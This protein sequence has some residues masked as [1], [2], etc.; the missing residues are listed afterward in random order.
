MQFRSATWISS[1]GVLIFIAHAFTTS[2]QER[3]V[4]GPIMPVEPVGA[5][6]DAFK[7]HDVVA[8]VDAHG[9]LQNHAFRL[10]LIRDL[11]FTA[12]V[13][14]IVVELGNARYQDVVDR[15]V[16][17]EDVA[18]A[19]LRNAWQDTTVMTAANNYAMMQELFETV[20]VVN[21]GLP[22]DR[23][24][25]IIL[26]DP[27]IDWG[28]VRDRAAHQSWLALRDSYPAAV[29]QV[30][31]L[32]RK[33]KALLLYGFL[34]FQRKNVASNYDMQ[35]REA[36]TIVS[37][38]E[39][40][41]PA[42]VFTIW[43]LDPAKVAVDV[44]TWPVPSLALVRGTAAGAADFALHAGPVANA[45][46]SVRDGKFVPVPREEWRSMRTEEQIDGLLYLGPSS[47]RTSRKSH[48]IPPALCADPD[49]LTMHLDRMEVAGVPSGEGDRLKEYCTAVTSR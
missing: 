44:G 14:D 4:P 31:V 28:V 42:K 13:N 40:T 7:T 2:A 43:E 45:R 1:A 25:R 39:S 33:R 23:Q 12:V 19:S 3:P 47:A 9:D 30:E 27:P 49:F 21:A 20:R 37:I 29:V 36:Q 17:G 5:I 18:V 8:L 11:R 34:H 10:A 41:T 48:E 38:L 16:G 15:F 46:V 35:S 24:L 6:V 32:A 26:G 22:R